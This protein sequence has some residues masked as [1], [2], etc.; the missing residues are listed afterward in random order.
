[1]K[2]R[3]VMAVTCV[4]MPPFFFALPLRQM[5]L[6]FIGPVPVNSQILAIKSSPLVQRAGKDNS[7]G[8]CCKPHF[9]LFWAPRE[10]FQNQNGESLS[11]S[12]IARSGAAMDLL[13]I[14]ASGLGASRVLTQPMNGAIEP[15]TYPANPAVAILGVPFDNVTRAEATTLIGQML[16]SRQP[17]YLVTA[18]IDFALQ[19][20]GDAELRNILF[21]A[22]MV[23][24]D[25][26]PL[27]W[28]ARLLG[29]S[30]PERLTGADL[31]PLLLQVAGERTLRLYYLGATAEAA[32]QAVASLKARH[33]GLEVA[34][35][36]PDSLDL[37]AMDLEKVRKSITEAH[38]D[39][40]F[41]AFGCPLQ[42]KWI[43]M[44]FQS[45]GVPVALGVGSTR[46]FLAAQTDEKELG[47]GARLARLP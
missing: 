36:A 11:G 35:S 37:L 6:P 7:A 27:A 22:H 26:A 24:C 19:A 20:Q 28:A 32:G 15:K 9:R 25:G 16:A 4:P 33:P 21:D 18:D 45:L 23:L 17:H 12:E 2:R 40:L 38:P 3:L 41:V 31:V 10:W 5:W 29:N 42:E 44:H 34:G 13:F 43:A 30:L 8:G 14:R 39:I 46:E 1:M 47:T